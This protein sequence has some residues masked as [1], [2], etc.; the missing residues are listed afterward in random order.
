MIP[1]NYILIATQKDKAIELQDK[2][3]DFAKIFNWDLLI[4]IWVEQGLVSVPIFIVQVVW[5]MVSAAMVAAVAEQKELDNLVNTL[6]ENKL[7]MC[8]PCI[9]GICSDI[10]QVTETEVKNT[11]DHNMIW[12]RGSPGVRKS[13]L[14][15]S[16]LT[17]LQD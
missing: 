14:A 10:L 1:V 13:A 4:E 12:I 3:D 15:A 8:K 2:L 16:I 5:F 6:G 17:Q 11:G 9:E 7:K